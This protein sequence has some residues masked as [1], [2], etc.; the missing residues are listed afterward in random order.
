[1]RR[2]YL[3]HAS[4][5]TTSLI[6]RRIARTRREYLAHAPANRSAEEVD[7]PQPAREESNAGQ[8]PHGLERIDGVFGFDLGEGLGYAWVVGDELPGCVEQHPS[9]LVG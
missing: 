6:R 9:A 2:E 3:A 7:D 5:R 1:M 4:A 8:C